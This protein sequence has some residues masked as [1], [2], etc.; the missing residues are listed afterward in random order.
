[1]LFDAKAAQPKRVI[2]TNPTVAL[3]EA[4]AQ[5]VAEWLT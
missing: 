4:K 1:M 5:A 2:N 3:T